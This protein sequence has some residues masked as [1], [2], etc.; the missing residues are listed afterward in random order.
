MTTF[1]TIK[2]YGAWHKYDDHEVT[3]M[4]SSGVT[5]SAAYIL[6]YAAVN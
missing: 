3:K 6:F 4:S 1:I 5:T 2:V